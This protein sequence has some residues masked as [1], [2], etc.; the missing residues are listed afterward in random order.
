MEP[1]TLTLTL[2]TSQK[3]QWHKHNIYTYKTEPYG[4]L[5][6]GHRPHFGQPRSKAFTSPFCIMMCLNIYFWPT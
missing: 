6:L 3:M 4:G 2:S 1:R 5:K